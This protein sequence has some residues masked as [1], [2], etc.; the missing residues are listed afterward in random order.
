MSAL[1]HKQTCALQQAMTPNSDR[2]G[3]IPQKAMSALPRK[4]TC[5]AQ[6]GM[7]ALGQKRKRRGFT[8]LSPKADILR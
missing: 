8:L 5:A 6:K 7:S 2:E 4:R 3:E 1:G